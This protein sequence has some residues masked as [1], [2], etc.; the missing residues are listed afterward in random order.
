MISDAESL[1]TRADC[2][3]FTGAVRKRNE[4]FARAHR[5]QALHDHDIAA[6]ER[7]R[8]NLHEHFVRAGSPHRCIGHFQA[9]PLLARADQAI[10]FLSRRRAH[11]SSPGQR[12]DRGDPQ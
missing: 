1:H 10:L 11:G 6:V 12:Q 7:G 5:I 9:E 2:N 3:D 4:R 8:V